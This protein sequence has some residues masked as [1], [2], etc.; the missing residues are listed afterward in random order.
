[1]TASI[2]IAKARKPTMRAMHVSRSEDPKNQLDSLPY[3]R[4]YLR[5]IVIRAGDSCSII[6]DRV[7]IETFRYLQFAVW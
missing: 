5:Y 4:W 2:A 1:M 6:C 7:N 3:S